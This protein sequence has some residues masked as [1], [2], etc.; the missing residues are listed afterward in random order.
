[1]LNQ[2]ELIKIFCAAAE[3]RSFR[4]AAALLGKSPQ[5]ITRAIKELE[6]LRGE[7]LFYRSTRSLKITREGEALAREAGMLM[8]NIERLVIRNDES[9]DT[10]PSG[11]ISL[12]MP[13]SFGR[14]FVVPA[15]NTFRQR[16]PDITVTCILTDTHSDVVDEK[17]DIGL[18]TGFLRDN[19]YVA[20]KIRDVRFY[21]LG[22]PELISRVGKPVEM[23]HLS[24]MPVV[25]LLDHCT[26]RFWPWT[27]D[28]EKSF[29]PDAPRFVTDDLD[30]YCDVIVNGAGF[31]QLA[32]YL[33]LPLIEKGLVLPV[34]QEKMPSTWGLYIYRPQTG[35]V[36][37]RIRLLF[38][39]LSE[40]LQK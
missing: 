6:A 21:I 36:P 23:E 29:T 11:H 32:D 7:I 33:A 16:Y 18:R 37:A 39:Y 15:L 14:R 28:N 8:K 38:D 24:Q 1:M 40:K 26:G 9:D 5:S 35:P 27:F 4:Q 13:A 10:L 17:I 2:F 12:T 34:M 31:G 22:T 20:R 3:S 19:R 25:A 30:A